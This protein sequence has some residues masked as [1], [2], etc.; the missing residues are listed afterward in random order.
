[1]KPGQQTPDRD[2]R[3]ESWKSIANFLGKSVR[4][5][6]RW[7]AE[8]GLPVHRHMH[9]RQGTVYAFA[10]EIDRWRTRRGHGPAPALDPQPRDERRGLMVLP[11]E[12]VGPNAD[13]AWLASGIADALIDRLAGIRE[14]RVLSRMSTRALADRHASSRIAFG[15]L[16]QQHGIGYVV[17][18]TTRADRSQLQVS[19]RLVDIVNDAVVSSEHFEGPL[20]QALALQGRISMHVAD[21][22]SNEVGQSLRPD[23]EPADGM[24]STAEWECLVLARQDAIK[25]RKSGLDA[26]LERLKQGIETLGRRPMLLAALGRTW[27]QARETASELGP[28]PL[29]RARACADEL[30]DRGIQHPARLQLEGWIRYADGNIPGA[31]RA[32]QRAN[33][34][35]PDD[36][37][38]LG[39][40]INC[41]LISDRAGEAQPHIERLTRIDPLTPITAR[42]P[43][44]KLLLDGRF[45]EAIPHYERMCEM[46]PENPMARA[47]LVQAL[48]LAG[49]LDDLDAVVGDFD[50]D[51][52]PGRGLDPV[53]RIARFLAAAAAAH[54]NAAHW[55]DDSIHALSHASDVLPRLLANGYA[56]MGDR[57]QAMF[58]IDQAIEHGF[59]HL[60]YLAEHDPL[61]AP[62]R[63]TPE[64]QQRLDRL[65]A[66]NAEEASID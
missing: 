66:R 40:L 64:F 41:L 15:N 57:E 26:A 12:H 54:Q 27:L 58:W 32:L 46:D 28:G 22:L 60:P 62:L 9:H 8:E 23:A 53:T 18:G 4:T 24:A 25:W 11:F 19:I 37:E 43:G 38:T 34:L 59:S 42:L 61:L 55:L 45:E 33:E 47:F 6:K 14:L 29:R 20:E 36:P 2:E 63:G 48:T 1:M 52:A 50:P 39:L 51:N 17:E 16:V 44:W 3:L 30:S 10:E 35:Q 21:R 49:H 7:E 31:I 56:A 65:R 13:H 5:A